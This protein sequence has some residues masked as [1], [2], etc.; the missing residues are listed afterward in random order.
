MC[1]QIQSS[2]EL[3]IKLAI[4]IKTGGAEGAFCL[5]HHVLSFQLILAYG[6]NVDT[7]L[8]TKNLEETV[9]TLIKRK[10]PRAGARLTLRNGDLSVLFSLPGSQFSQ[11]YEF[12]VPQTF[13][14]D[15]PPVAFF[16][17]GEEII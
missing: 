1:R 3:K 10:S 14:P 7:R 5:Y 2:V 16:M 9:S 4:D 15:T 13:G 6:L 11:V 8:D 12:Q 17:E